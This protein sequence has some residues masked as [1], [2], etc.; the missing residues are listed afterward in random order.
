MQRFL[1]TVFRHFDDVWA[2]EDGGGSGG[3]RSVL[4]KLD[5]DGKNFE[6]VMMDLHSYVID[7]DVTEV[8][9]LRD[10]CHR[11]ETTYALQSDGRIR[12]DQDKRPIFSK[13]AKAD[14]ARA[15]D[16]RFHAWKA[17]SLFFLRWWWNGPRGAPPFPNLPGQKN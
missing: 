14:G 6:A 5:V 13:E 11:I 1:H 7:R 2:W 16:C 4:E 17:T 15:S 10:S 12:L 8:Y 3:L 9:T